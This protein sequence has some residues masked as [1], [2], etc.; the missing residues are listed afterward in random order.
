MLVVII[1]LG[2]RLLLVI[3]SLSIIFAII[4]SCSLV[5]LGQVV[6]SSIDLKPKHC[7]LLLL[8]F[9]L[10]CNYSTWRGGFWNASTPNTVRVVHRFLTGSSINRTDLGTL[11]LLRH[12]QSEWNAVPT[13]TGW[14]DAKLTV[15][16]IEEAIEAGLLLRS[17]GFQKFDAAFTSN[18]DRAS[19]TCQLALEAAG[20]A[21]STPMIK[22]A[23]LNERHYGCLQGRRKN[24]IELLAEYGKEHLTKWRR[25]F[26]AAPPPMDENH[27]YYELPP[28]PLTESLEDCQKRVLRYWSDEILPTLQPGKTILIAAHSNTLRA[29]V[30][31]LDDVPE[32]Q[33]SNLHIPNSVPCIYR[34]NEDG[35]S[36]LPKL[37]NSA[38]ATRG[39]WLFSLENQARLRSKIGGTG[40]FLQSVFD[41]WD[42]NGDGVLSLEEIETGLRQIMGGEDIAITFVA[43][44][45]LEEID[46]DGTSSLSSEEFQK[47]ATG[48]YQRYMPGFMDSASTGSLSSVT[49]S[50]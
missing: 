18:L 3:Y 17:R 50:Q 15:R 7:K 6:P 47:Y 1:L 14:C 26:R 43:A 39:H 10:K 12:G 20:C 21:S 49:I 33:I 30:A 9:R 45:I 34:F 31:H 41:A 38:G 11:V 36:V 16:G 46:M 2:L 37:E 4:T 25:E 29:L 48:V 42:T 27:E 32:D 28:A 24:D 8:M 44:K 22:S 23:S 35:T 13:F 19:R 5:L 40:S